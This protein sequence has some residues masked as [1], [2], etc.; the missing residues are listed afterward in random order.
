MLRVIKEVRRDYK[1]DPDRIYMTGHSMGAEG[2]W[3]IGLKYPHLFAAIAPMSGRAPLDLIKNAQFL[4]VYLAHGAKDRQVDV[5]HSRD[6]YQLLKNLGSEVVYH[7]LPN[8]G[9]YG[10]INEEFRA[11]FDWFDGHKKQ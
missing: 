3:L 8:A 7:E 2:T 5:Q 6:A 4:P 11:M 9:H 1:I 10:F